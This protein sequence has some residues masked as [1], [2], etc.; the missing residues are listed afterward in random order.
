MI[1]EGMYITAYREEDGRTIEL[2][3]FRKVA[4]IGFRFYNNTGQGVQ[5]RSVGLMVSTVLAYFHRFG[6]CGVLLFNF[7]EI[8]LQRLHDEIESIR[9]AGR[10]VPDAGG[11]CRGGLGSGTSASSTLPVISGE[12]SPDGRVAVLSAIRHFRSRGRPGRAGLAP[13]T[14]AGKIVRGLARESVFPL[15]R[16]TVGG[17]S[18]ACHPLEICLRFT[19][20]TATDNVVDM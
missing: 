10:V 18:H 7:E 2:L 6:G 4:T 13:S 17:R 9:V 16:V 15:H 19:E 11:R 20:S 1:T 14:V 8:T 5:G 12:P 3:G